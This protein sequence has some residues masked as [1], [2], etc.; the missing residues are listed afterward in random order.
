[1]H[2]RFLGAARQVTGSRHL[3]RSG[4][5]TLLVDCGMFQERDFTAR[6]WEPSPVPPGEIDRVLL[7]HGHLDHCGLLPKLVR[8]GFGG[9]ILCTAPSAD[10][11]RIVWADAARIQVEDAAYKKKRHRREGR[12]GAH[13]EAPLYTPEDAEA[14]ERRLKVVPYDKPIEV[15]PGLTCTWRDA[16]HILGSAMLELVERTDAGEQTVVFSGDVGTT[17]R[18]LMHDP[19]RFARADH[20]VMESTYGDRDHAPPADLGKALAEIVHETVDAGGNLVVP[21]F[22]IDRAQELLW[23]FGELARAGAIPR[24]TIFLDSPMAIGVTEVYKRYPHLLDDE[25]RALVDRGEHPFQFPG[26]H[27][28]RTSDESRSINSIRGSCVIMAG[29][30]M[31]TGGRVKHHLRA[32]LEREASTVLFVGF[33]ATGTLGRQILRG[34]ER[35]R[36]HNRQYQVKARVRRLEGLSA[37]A[38]RSG[39]LTWIGAFER[40]PASILLVHGEEEAARSLEAALDE[41]TSSAVEVPAYEE[42]WA[43]E[44][45][46]PAVRRSGGGD[47]GGGEGGPA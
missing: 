6:N 35:V 40:D 11:T 42:E 45:G 24:V 18:P 21:T 9:E 28:V 22:A 31:C 25:T 8:E 19:H 30:G 12:R 1:M 23:W 14:A 10:L 15:A 5:R 20:V 43:L 32:N 17:D 39:L 41:R 44:P 47:G 34:D 36:I 38:D 7:T 4:G 46:T 3:V 33:Q 2:V 26:L 13:P 27:F 16:G 37:H 29:S